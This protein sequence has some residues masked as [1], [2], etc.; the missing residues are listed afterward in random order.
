MIPPTNTSSRRGVLPIDYPYKYELNERSIIAKNMMIDIR[1]GL[2]MKIIW[3]LLMS[4]DFKNSFGFILPQIFDVLLSKSIWIYLK[5]HFMHDN[6]HKQSHIMMK[7]RLAYV[8]MQISFCDETMSYSNHILILVRQMD[9][10]LW[11]YIS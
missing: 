2:L 3:R 11:P 5:S 6:L 7:R 10:L 1:A 8:Y 4:F 9:L